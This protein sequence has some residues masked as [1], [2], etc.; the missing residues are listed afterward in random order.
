[1]EYKEG[2]LLSIPEYGKLYKF[3]CGLFIINDAFE[4]K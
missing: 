2:A 1:M 4:V 3:Y